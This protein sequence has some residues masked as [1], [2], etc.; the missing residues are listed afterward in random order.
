MPDRVDEFESI[1]KRASKARFEYQRPNIKKVLLITDLAQSER[2]TLLER[3]RQFLAVLQ[4][5]S[6]DWKTLGNSD[7]DRKSAL[8]DQVNQSHPD[9]IVTYRNLKQ[10][11]KDTPHSLG[12]YLDTLTQA[13]AVPVLI[14]PDD[15]FH[16][17]GTPGA[18]STVLVVTDHL[19]GDHRLINYAVRLTQKNG[20]LHLCH[21]EDDAVFRYYMSAIE[22]IPA[23][24]THLAEQSLREQLLKQPSDY[25]Q[26]CIEVLK[27]HGITVQLQPHVL[28]GHRL[29][30]YRRLLSEYHTDLLVLNTKDQDQLAMHG[31]AYPIVV[32]FRD[33]P[34]LML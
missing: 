15:Q 28:M 13:T 20:Q 22:R 31:L 19:A 14:L 23:I 24:D 10:S 29:Q 21:V 34:L 32:E 26:H 18:T 16:R 8:L 3:V 4:S 1:F 11:D 5:D 7:Y 2:D 17:D 30:D 27:Q 6:P 12:V 33:V 25:I 9:L